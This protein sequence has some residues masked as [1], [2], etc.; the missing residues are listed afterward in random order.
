MNKRTIVIISVG[1]GLFVTLLI[2]KLCIDGTLTDDS[3][4]LFLEAAKK[5]QGSAFPVRSIK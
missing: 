2:L 1:A 3:G 5:W 4:D